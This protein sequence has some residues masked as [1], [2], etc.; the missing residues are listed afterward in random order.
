MVRETRSHDDPPLHE[1]NIADTVLYE[2]E[3]QPGVELERVVRDTGQDVRDHTQPLAVRLDDLE[4]DEVGDVVRPVFGWRQ[5]VTQD[6]QL[7][8][9]LDC[10]VELDRGTSSPHPPRKDDDGLVSVHAQHGA[11]VEA[12]SILARV[13][14]HKRAVEPVRSAH[15]AD[16]YE[17]VR[18]VRAPNTMKL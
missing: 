18:R 13:L 11:D 2:R 7:G 15:T 5:L 1:V 10:A 9:A 14:D 4:A 6:R 16:A 8:V 3:Q 17:R 12:T